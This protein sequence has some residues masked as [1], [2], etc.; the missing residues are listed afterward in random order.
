MSLYHAQK[1]APSSFKVHSGGDLLARGGIVAAGLLCLLLLAWGHLGLGAWLFP[2]AP[3]VPQQQATVG[4]YQVTLALDSGQLTASGPNTIS[5]RLQDRAGQAINGA[6][7]HVVSEMTTMPM[8][9]PAVDAL[10]NGAGQYSIHPRF[11]MAGDW[12]LTITISAPGQP[13]QQATFSVGVRW[14]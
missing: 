2:P 3:T 8:T 11:S 5:L 6:S 7:L 1:V 4:P 10:A 14:S 13:M 9:A 12:R